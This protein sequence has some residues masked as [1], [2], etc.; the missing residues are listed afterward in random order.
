M[1]NWFGDNSKI[2]RSLV[3]S[4]SNDTLPATQHIKNAVIKLPKS[5]PSS[6]LGEAATET[7]LLSDIVPGFNG[8]STSS[9]Y[10]G[11]VI[12]GVLPIAEVAGR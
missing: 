2:T 4:A 6:G 3:D 8:P 7:H 12:G 1:R 10:Y 5:L 11:F 9:N